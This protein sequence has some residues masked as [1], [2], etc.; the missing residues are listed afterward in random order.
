MI[1]KNCLVLNTSTN[2]FIGDICSACLNFEK[3]KKIDWKSRKKIFL[4]LFKRDKKSD[5]DC[6]VPVSGGKDSTYQVIKLLET[7]SKPLAVCID[8][9]HMSDI[10]KKNLENLRKLGV[11]LCTIKFAKNLSNKLSR[12]G[13][14]ETGDIEW[15]EN[16]AVN[17]GVTNL[18]SKLGIKKILWGENSQNEYGGPASLGESHLLNY[19]LWLKKFGGQL[20]LDVKKVSKKYNLILPNLF[21]NYLPFKQLKKIKSIYLGYFFKWDGFENYNFV[22]K[23]GFKSFNKRVSGS[24]LKY[25]NIDNYHDGIHDYFRYLKI[26]MGRTHDQVSRLLRRKMISKSKGLEYIRKFDGEFPKSYLNVK[27]EKILDDIEISNKK[28]IE[29]SVKYT[30]WNIFDRRKSK[31]SKNSYHPQLKSKFK[32]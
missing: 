31:I 8:T 1:C 11:E 7:G 15:I 13:L 24:I 14:I 10:G 26:G 19:K 29:L 17:C 27:L 21:L 22:K 12:I 25:E 6:V 32:L 9:G 2:K 3:R 5:Y 30:N 18:T 28:F 20:N 23:Y 16:M 4:S